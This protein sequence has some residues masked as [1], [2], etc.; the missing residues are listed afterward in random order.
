MRADQTEPIV[1]SAGVEGTQVPIS[2]HDPDTAARTMPQSDADANVSR[3][4]DGTSVTDSATTLRCPPAGPVASGLRRAQQ[5]TAVYPSDDD[6]IPSDGFDGNFDSC[7]IA[8]APSNLDVPSSQGR[9]QEGPIGY[10]FTENV[11]KHAG[12]LSMPVQ[13]LLTN[14]RIVSGRGHDAHPSPTGSNPF[15]TRG[16][17][18]V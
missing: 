1:L 16:R 3:K 6:C 12:N 17:R 14:Q 9:L 18:G 8:P 5:G 2:C 15:S 10:E 7:L 11:P 13:T 4:Y